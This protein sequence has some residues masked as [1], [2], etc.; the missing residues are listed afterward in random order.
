M[1][2]RCADCG[3]DGRLHARGRCSPCYWIAKREA[4]KQTCPGCGQ[5]A[6]LRGPA[7]GPRCWRCRRR[8]APRRRP[9]PR[10]CR[11]CG[12]LR[13]HA[14]HGLCG[15][16]W[17]RDPATVGGWL[18]GAR[19]RLGVRCPDWFGAF[20]EHLLARCAP[21]I[22]LRHLR[23]VE[24]ALQAG[25]DRPSAL[26]A[27]VTDRGR[28]G[29]SPGATARLLEGFLVARGWRWPA[30]SRA[31][32]PTPAARAGSSA[33]PGRCAPT[34]SGISPGCSKAA[35]GHA[36]PASDRSATTRSSNAWRCWPPSPDTSTATA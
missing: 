20:A 25:H 1:Q 32:S 22:C 15:R 28:S 27:A 7:S 21:A 5:R 2:G 31:G 3:T 33:A 30:T 34:S 36:A 29:R 13:R 6:R 26:I 14:A 11:R 18:Q 24:R 23:R 16:C 19:G 12:E 8:E 10:R 35:S 4:E 17:Q 9:T